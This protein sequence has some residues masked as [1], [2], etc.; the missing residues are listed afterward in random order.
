VVAPSCTS[1]CTAHEGEIDIRDILA[2]LQALSAY[3]PSAGNSLSLPT[4]L[5]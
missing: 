1:A 2:R 4:H 3:I 5:R